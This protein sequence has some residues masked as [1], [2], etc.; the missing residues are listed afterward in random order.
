MK[1]RTLL[2]EH[3]RQKKQVQRKLFEIQR[4]E[5]RKTSLT[6]INDGLPKG[7]AGYTMEDYMAEKEVLEQEL[8][9]LRR[10]EYRLYD[11]IFSSFV[12]MASSREID[13]LWQRYIENKNWARIEI[14]LGLSH[15][16]AMALHRSALASFEKVVY[17]T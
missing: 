16:Y 11:Q 1:G 17:N 12:R 9:A 2:E 5:A 3:R 7:S 15:S 14:D 4:L 10:T 8:A 13:I 6:I